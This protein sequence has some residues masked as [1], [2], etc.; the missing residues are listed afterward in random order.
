[1]KEVVQATLPLRRVALF[2]SGVGYF[3]HGGEVEGP[4]RM[5]LPFRHE[6]VSDVLKSLMILSSEADRPAVSY[7]AQNSLSDSLASQKPDLSNNPSTAELL[8]AVR[9]AVVE[10]S[11]SS[12]V[13]TGRVLGVE[14]RPGDSETRPESLVS[15]VTGG[16]V[17]LISLATVQGYRLLDAELAA[18]VEHALELLF[19]EASTRLRQLEVDLS[20]ESARTVSLSY[21]TSAPVWK[22]SYRLDL[23]SESGVI[24]GWAIVDNTSETDWQ[25]V[26]LSLL[27]GRPSSFRQRLYEPY[28]VSK[29]EVPLNIAGSS[30]VRTHEDAYDELRDIES[31]V[32]APLRSQFLRSL[33]LAEDAMGIDV[34]KVGE[35]FAL[36][37]PQPISLAR[38]QSAMLEFARGPVQVRRVSIFSGS[39]L[40]YG[41]EANPMLA[42]ELANTLGSPLPA[43]AITVYQDGM[44]AGDALQEFLPIGV[45]RLVSYGADLAVRGSFETQREDVVASVAIAK[46]VLT[47]TWEKRDHTCYQFSNDSD[48]ERNLVIEHPRDGLELVSPATPSAQ[49]ASCWRFEVKL[50]PG[51]LRFDVVTKEPKVEVVN[52]IDRTADDLAKFV[53]LNLPGSASQLLQEAVDLKR[54]EHDAR[55][56]V[57]QLEQAEQRIVSDQQR[58]RENMKAVGADTRSGAIYQ[59]RLEAAELQLK[60]LVARLGTA[61]DKANAAHQALTDYIS[62]LTTFQR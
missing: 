53:G 30:A 36:T 41:E 13:I 7:P 43:G 59:E 46:G 12:G 42:V 3:E 50:P 47:A 6:D 31:D 48:S 32:S 5:V 49:T 58:L 17:Q 26:Q 18:S 24:Q 4:A 8:N 14:T 62:T 22:A 16:G 11:S 20:G 56:A 44:Y 10:V 23:S 1:M 19:S 34:K 21:V 39:R 52:L 15:L 55:E 9:G 54:G 27:V 29:P 28:Y 40:R 57:A 33:R 38:K 35:Q 2:T 25:D 61:Q 37:F 45:H 60:D 51:T